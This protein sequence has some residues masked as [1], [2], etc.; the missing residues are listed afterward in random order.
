MAFFQFTLDSTI[1]QDPEGWDF[2]SPAYTRLLDTRGASIMRPDGDIIFRED[3]Y[4]Y[5]KSVY[6]SSGNCGE[7][8]IKVEYKEWSGGTFAT[9]F[10]GTFR[11]NEVEWD[12][13]NKGVSVTLIHDNSF[14]AYI[15][16]NADIPAQL[17]VGRSKNDET[18]TAVT[19]INLDFFD[20]S[21]AVGSYTYTNRPCYQ[22]YDCLEFLV[23][24]MSDGDLQ[25]DS[26]Y[27]GAGGDGE[28]IFI[29]KGSALRT[30]TD[31]PPTISWTTILKEL[32]VRFNVVPVIDESTSPPTIR[33]EDS[34]TTFEQ[35]VSHTFLGD[36]IRF[37]KRRSIPFSS[38]NDVYNGDK[39]ITMFTVL[40]I[41][42]NTT[43]DQGGSFSYPDIRWKAWGREEYHVID[44][45]GVK[46]TFELV[47]DWIVGSNTIE[48][49]LVTPNTA[50]DDSIFLVETDYPANTRALKFDVINPG[51][52]PFTYN[53][54]LTN[55]SIADRFLGAVPNSIASYLG[56]GGD[57]FS[58]LR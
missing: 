51:A 40:D 45:P 49:V 38:G 11:L 6:D 57:D 12:L 44:C 5:L 36:D 19:P 58:T 48:D 25:F 31:A 15:N 14:M 24:F 29:I 32:F 46:Q 37:L 56:D 41:G 34:E 39:P 27:F 4:D 3:G 22:V 10:E 17:D 8:D 28:G 30:G 33:V 47:G 18:I 52:A 35:T 43:T 16:S 20:P 50:H 7:V 23:E 13:E 2:L 1:V 54:G 55:Q 9:L 53:D 21:L 42:S 26:T